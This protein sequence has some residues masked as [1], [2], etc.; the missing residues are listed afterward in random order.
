M[1]F[2]NRYRQLFLHSKFVFSRFDQTAI[3][4]LATHWDP[5]FKRLRKN[6][7]TE[8]NLLEFDTN[9]KEKVKRGVEPPS[10]FIYK[11]I[12]ITSSSIKVNQKIFNP[13]SKI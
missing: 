7:F 11:P 4:S 13:F 10:S 3:R 6:K 9:T 8:P 5:K 2:L 1:S 12:N